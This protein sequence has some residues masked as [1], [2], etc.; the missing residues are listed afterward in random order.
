VVSFTP[1]NLDFAR[2]GRSGLNSRVLAL[3]GE[4]ASGEGG[5]KVEPR[6]IAALTPTE[7]KEHAPLVHKAIQDE[8]KGELEVKV[9]EQATALAALEP[10][11]EITKK[12]RELLGLAEGENPLEKLTNLI[13]RLEEG[14]SSEIKTF[15][16]DLVGKKVKTE[17]GQAVL[18]RL[19]GE[20]HTEYDGELTDDL[21]KKIEDDFNNKLEDDEDIKVLVGEMATW[22]ESRERS[23]SRGGASLGGRTQGGEERGRGGIGEGSNQRRGSLTVTKRKV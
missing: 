22:E 14:A 19:I 17:R 15:I 12:V 13:A 21:K 7:I 10:E 18:N 4:M 16:K 9:G 20:M 1:E 11:V 3:A 23:T 5:W 2:K 8:A 6:E